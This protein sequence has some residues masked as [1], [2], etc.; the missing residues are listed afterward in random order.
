MKFIKFSFIYLLMACIFVSCEDTLDVN[1]DPLAA[2]SADPNAILP[3]VLV[4]YSNRFETELGSRMM[5]VPQHLNFCFNSPQQGNTSSFL[6]GNT[7][8]MY[9]VQVLGNLALV[10]NDAI[11][12]GAGFNNVNAIAKILKAKSFFELSCIWNDVPFSEALD[13]V[14]FPSP[15]FDAQ[16][17][18][19]EGCVDILDEAIALID[20][21][22]GGQFSVST[23]DLIY[24]GNI[25]SWRKWANSLR[26]RILMLLRNKDTSVDG[27][28]VAA[29]GQPVI[30]TNAEAALLEYPGGAGGENAYQAILT[31]FWGP[32]GN[33]VYTYHAPGAPFHD[34]LKD[35][36]DP[37]Y[38]L[39]IFDPNDAGPPAQAMY[40]GENDNLY[41][42]ISNAAIRG[43][44]PHIMFLPSEIDF[45]RAEL[46][47]LDVTSDDPQ[48]HFENG[49]TKILEFWGGQIPGA[50]ATIDAATIADY[51]SNYGTAT[52]TD[53][54]EQLYLEAF[55]RPIV[56]WNSVR[57]TKVPAMAEVP[58]TSIST[59]LKRFDYPPNEVAANVNTPANPP[60]DTPQ[61]FEN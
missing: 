58:G 2:S 30:E 61:W 55:L 34:L 50:T 48:M 47:M 10:E 7:W 36:G 23:G 9:Y 20:A 52:M 25:D 26:I 54:H 51:V 27:E 46:A 6:T 13:G 29:L 32:A 28:L 31:A 39:L 41:A 16:K 5:D 49:L 44:L 59:I 37:R 35:S 45:Y 3:Y 17:D 4:Q 38:D 1:T 18:V 57:R 19:F 43:T 12:A 33:E 14:N 42:A 53:I 56:A 60:T 40:A 24:N 11:S 8:R 22:D 21:I 15:N